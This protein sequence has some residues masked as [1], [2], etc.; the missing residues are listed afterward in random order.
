MQRLPQ[1]YSLASAATEEIDALIKI[2]LAAGSLFEGTGLIDDSALGDH[3]P[4]DIFEQAIENGNLFTAR[5]RKGMAVGF[6]LT[7]LRQ[8]TFYLDQISVHPDHGRKGLGRALVRRVVD[9]ARL[10]HLKSVTLSTFRD[11]AWN[12]PFYRRLGFKEVTRKKMED[13]MLDLEKVQEATLD[14]SE[15]C[16]M[17]RK[18][19]WL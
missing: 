15:R 13:W 14:I 12:G 4:A 1:G 2:D 9:E 16:F 18:V 8:N 11:L 6:A 7:S 17:R 3:V 10:R 5:D 19:T